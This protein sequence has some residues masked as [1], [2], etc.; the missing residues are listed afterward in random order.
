MA[1]IDPTVAP[2]IAEEHKDFIKMLA[3]TGIFEKQL[4]VWAYAA[5]YAIKHELKTDGANVRRNALPEFQHLDNET[6]EGLVMA[7]GAARPET[8][9]ME[10]KE[11]AVEL[12]VLAS[13]G[14]DVL[15][16]TIEGQGRNGAYEILLKQ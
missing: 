6:L 2:F 9:Q 15:R 5:A 12:S 7:L 1:S 11:V 4:D 14:M 8:K 13:V 10:D 16:P 3:D